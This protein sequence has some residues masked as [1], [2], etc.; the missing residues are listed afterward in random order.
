MPRRSH[1]L[2]RSF[3]APEAA[4]TSPVSHRQPLRVSA[5][6]AHDPLTIDTSVH[7]FVSTLI[8]FCVK[9]LVSAEPPPMEQGDPIGLIE[10]RPKGAE[11]MS[12]TPVP[13]ADATPP[14]P[15]TTPGDG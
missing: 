11:T 1:C 9:S 8:T 13:R 14:P 2:K 4:R 3:G 12:R 10:R 7:R 6:I 5:I 15:G